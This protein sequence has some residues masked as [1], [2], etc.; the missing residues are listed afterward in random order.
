MMITA[1][2]ADAS[3]M[4]SQVSE[5]GSGNNATQRQDNSQLAEGGIESE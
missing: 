2:D 5:M 1:V 3:Y 4:A